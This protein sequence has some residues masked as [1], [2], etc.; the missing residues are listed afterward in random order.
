M[1]AKDTVCIDFGTAQSKVVLSRPS[2]SRN[3]EV[4]LEI[5]KSATRLV[6]S[7]VLIERGGL[8]HF[9]QDA[10]D[11]S[12]QAGSAGR[13]DS[14]K[15]WIRGDLGQPIEHAYNP[16]SVAFTREDV[17]TLF[18]AKLLER[19]DDRLEGLRVHPASV[20]WRF[21]VPAWQPETMNRVLPATNRVFATAAAIVEAHGKELQH[22]LQA[23]AARKLLLEARK[24]G[25]RGTEHRI[26]MH[27]LE[28]VA[29]GWR[30]IRK[31]GVP[32]GLVLVVDVGAGTTDL[33]IFALYPKRKW[34]QLPG[35]QFALS[36][37]GDTLD[38]ILE[39]TIAKAAGGL[40]EDELVYVRARRRGWKETL[41]E[42]GKV[43]WNAGQRTNGVLRKDEFCSDP[44]VVTFFGDLRRA[45]T[46]LVR[47]VNQALLHKNSSAG[48]GLGVL[49]TGGGAA[50]PGL[51][52]LTSG[53][54]VYRGIAIQHRAIQQ[55]PDDLDLALR[56][57]FPVLAVA[58]GGAVFEQP[59]VVVHDIEPLPHARVTHSQNAFTGP[60]TRA[61]Y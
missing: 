55:W 17:L 7:S 26:D 32:A 51:A 28:P 58:L 2:A 46:D 61:L 34:V 50:L 42:R 49:L 19:A 15:T 35:L 23:A 52:D 30:R 14:L 59:D 36:I 31:A 18:I 44:R 41:F 47:E 38:D 1:N 37:A 54:H 53:Q 48:G 60:P 33:A 9:G 16:T 4:A 39:G 40:T 10:C 3:R 43:S 45:A 56:P 6:P 12:Q 29:A 20:Q 21:A 11:R 57:D 24:R 13:L 25:M 22:P 8:I 27:V 5:G